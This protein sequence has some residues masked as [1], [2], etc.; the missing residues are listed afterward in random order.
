MSLKD[1][2]FLRVEHYSGHPEVKAAADVLVNKYAEEMD[3]IQGRRKWISAA[4]KL[5]ASLWIRDDDLFRFGTKK[6]YFSKGKR[7]QAWMTPR[8]L[9]L[10]KAMEALG[11]LVKVQSEIRPKYSTKAKG[12]MTS[13]YQRQPKFIQLLNSLTEQDVELDIDLP[14]VTLCDEDEQYIELPEE[15][16]KTESY[17]R[18]TTTLNSHYELLSRSSIVNKEG[19]PLGISMLRYRRR[20]KSSMGIGGRFYSPFCN[21]SKNERLS[22]TINSESV[23]SLDFSQLHPTLI[24]LLS[25]GVGRETNLF[26]TDDVYHMPDY[27][28]L[29]RAAHKKF[30]NTILNAK[31]IDAAARSISTA[32]QYW[33]VIEDCPV[34][35]THKGKGK[36]L[37]NP[38]WSANPLSHAKQYVKDFMFRH[39]NLEHAASSA[40]WGTLQLLDSSILEY[41]IA[42]A[43]LND[44][45]V[46]PVHDEVVIPRQHKGRVGGYMVDGFHVVTKNKFNDHVPMITWSCLD[47]GY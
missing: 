27:S 16:L 43:T 3:F 35:I 45:P 19:K 8:T 1:T 21:L 4:R 38:V 28:E 6:D 22:I 14:L 13:V 12:G 39:P 42:K 33:D 2:T 44:I 34:F 32:E 46:F 47:E 5:I 18:T 36:R 41:T 37:G 9:K 7:K 25:Q 17:Q 11:W 20:F 10:F 24:L 15:Y 31:S 23:G 26:A 29:P 40:L 30:I